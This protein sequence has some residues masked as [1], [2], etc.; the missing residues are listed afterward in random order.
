MRI[1]VFGEFRAT[2]QYLI[3]AQL[4]KKVVIDAVWSDVRIFVNLQADMNKIP[5]I[6]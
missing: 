1:M 2:P 6:T 3:R 4:S 5:I